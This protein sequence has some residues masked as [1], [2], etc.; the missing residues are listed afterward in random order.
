MR[1][2]AGRVRPL[3]ASSR[4]FVEAY[5]DEDGTVA[6]RKLR[7]M[8]AGGRRGVSPNFR[9]W[10]A[11]EQYR[12]EAEKARQ[13]A[14]QDVGA[15]DRAFWLALAANWEKLAKEAEAPKINPWAT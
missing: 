1:R 4:K 8:N 6:S 13:T 10:V 12:N 7:G 15:R 11:A 3:A 14:N 5:V 9:Q 2:V